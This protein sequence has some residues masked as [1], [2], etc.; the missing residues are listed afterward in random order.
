MR[1]ISWLS[2]ASLLAAGLSGAAEPAEAPEHECTSWMVFFDLTGS[3]RNFLH[4][5]RDASSRNIAVLLSKPDSPRKW[6][7]LGNTGKAGEF[8]CMG[9]NASGLAGVM[10]SGEVCCENNDDPTKK[11][12][13]AIL[14]DILEKCDTARQAVVRLEALLAAK[15]Y[16]HKKRGS[17]FFF[18][19]PKE[20]YVCEIT[21][22]FCSPIRYDRGYVYRAN[23]WHNPGLAQRS[24]SSVATITDSSL[25][26]YVARTFLND[27]LDR[28]GR[29]TPD[30]SLELSR[31]IR[32]PENAPGTRSVCFK[33]TNSSATL[34]IDREFPDVLSFGRFA[35]GHPRHGICVPVP[36]CVEQVDRRMADLTWSTAVWARFDKLGLEAPIPE[37]WLDFEKNAFT[38]YDRYVEDARKLLKAGKKAEAAAMLNAEAAAI[39]QRAARLMGL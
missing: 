38:E 20:G 16:W 3:G 6:I 32:V 26:E 15:D 25:R 10:N 28:N 18:M 17:I 1:M 36:V 24:R 33:S 2:A 11:G 8:V 21:A 5:N 13:P 34:V 22:R 31:T 9:M 29:I 37:T 39:W 7:G 4:K 30:D 35:I 12:T 19:D 23:I 27:R 14:R